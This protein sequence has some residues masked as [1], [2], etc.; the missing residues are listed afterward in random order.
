MPEQT[1]ISMCCKAGV[2]KVNI[3]DDCGRESYF[4]ARYNPTMNVLFTC[5]ECG[6]PCNIGYTEKGE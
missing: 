4:L 1:I 5:Q 3:Y 2:D 6:K